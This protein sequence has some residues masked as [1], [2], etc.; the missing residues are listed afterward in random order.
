LLVN[1]VDMATNV[2]LKDSG[3]LRWVWEYQVQPGNML[4]HCPPKTVNAGGWHSPVA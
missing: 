3:S 1:G 4:W 2:T